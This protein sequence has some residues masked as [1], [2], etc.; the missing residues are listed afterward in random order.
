[1]RKD[2]ARDVPRKGKEGKCIGRSG[3]RLDWNPTAWSD[4]LLLLLLLFDLL[5]YEHF[6]R[7]IQATLIKRSPQ[8]ARASLRFS[9]TG[10]SGRLQV[11]EVLQ[12]LHFPSISPCANVRL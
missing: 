4:F 1:M 2:G 12:L 5:R 11:S 9:L 10:I 7:S 6:G 3:N 8:S